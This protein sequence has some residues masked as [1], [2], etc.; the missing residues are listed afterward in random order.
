MASRLRCVVCAALISLALGWMPK[1]GLI[2]KATRAGDL[3]HLRKIWEGS[4][5]GYF[6]LPE[7]E[8]GQ[9]PLM[10][11]CLAG[12]EQVVKFLLLPPIKAD[13]NKGK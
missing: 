3:D 4:S 7:A 10:A 9:T 11:A 13:P 6:D 1:K 5:S 8:T 2:H 12:Q